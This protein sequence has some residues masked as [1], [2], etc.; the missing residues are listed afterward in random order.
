MLTVATTL[1]S[2]RV[3]SVYVVDGVTKSAPLQPHE[4]DVEDMAK[5]KVP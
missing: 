3:R 1:L 2:C 4:K 5:W